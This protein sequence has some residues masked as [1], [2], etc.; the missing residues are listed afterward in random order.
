MYNGRNERKIFQ[1]K[2]QTEFG[3]G[4]TARTGLAVSIKVS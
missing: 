3:T 4:K 2:F 1:H